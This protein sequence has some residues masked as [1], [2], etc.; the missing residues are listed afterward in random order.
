MYYDYNEVYYFAQFIICTVYNSA[1]RHSDG[2]D[3][4]LGKG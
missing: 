2:A 3:E 4:V 1:K